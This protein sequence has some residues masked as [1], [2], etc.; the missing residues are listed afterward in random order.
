MPIHLLL[1][2]EKKIRS[3]LLCLP[4][5]IKQ[6]IAYSAD[7]ILSI[8]AVWFAFYLRTGEF[9]YLF[10]QYNGYDF[11]SANL[12][13]VIVF[14]PLFIING[15]YK[16]AFR[17]V[18]GMA[19]LNIFRA[20]LV[21]SLCY[22]LLVTLISFQGI[23]RTLGIIQPLVFFVLV[24]L[25]RLFVRL[26]LGQML[27]SLLRK[28]SLPKAIIY[29]A[30]QTGRDLSQSLTKSGDFEVI[31]FVDDDIHL[32]GSRIFGLKVS[33]PENLKSIV[34]ENG[35]SHVLLA[36][37]NIKNP[38]F[39]QIV[40]SLSGLKVS[41]KTI[42][43]ASDI[44]LQRK[45]I[46]QIRELTIDE[47][48]G[49]EAVHPFKDLL[50]KDIYYKNVLVTG[51][52]GS[53]GSELS[54]IILENKPKT[55]LLL[56]HN[57]YSLYSIEKELL[58]LGK[59]F[60]DM[61]TIVPIL[62]SVNDLDWLERVLKTYKPNTIYHA[63]AYKHVGLV[64]QNVLAG[65]RNN[66]L[67]TLDF[68]ELAS[69]LNIEK[70]VLVST[71]K[72][73]RPTSIM[74]ASKRLAELSVLNLAAGNVATTFAIVR[75]GNVLN[76]SGSVVPLFQE[77]IDRGGPVT[78]TDMRV[79]RYFMTINE[80]ASLV[81]QSGAIADSLKCKE[82]ESPIFLLD[83]GNPIKIYDLA[84][85]M[86]ELSG[87]SLGNSK[88]E[89]NNNC[90]IIFTGLKP[91]EKLTEELLIEDASFSTV[92]P[93]IKQANEATDFPGELPSLIGG[94]RSCVENHNTIEAVKLLQKSKILVKS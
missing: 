83:M 9:L 76:S 3:Y 63:A 44:V 54:R 78:V 5:K 17:F 29:G 33:K 72:A 74:G 35:I 79:T 61:P 36:M 52:G 31:G 22:S 13:T 38:R 81:I 80:A 37:P 84:V 70:F 69:E 68:A 90:E 8:F 24:A 34:S 92:H 30:G 21:Y 94:L 62:G 41:V 14:T 16:S 48:L 59:N 28:K 26:W 32:H 91:G 45:E 64:E 65:I 86:I 56:E 82:R 11:I 6:I 51:A 66:T 57:E 93:K 55:I 58:Q 19:L 18:S 85:K 42:P 53:I 87:R 27:S 23:P 15:M 89:N 88:T 39:A 10:N 71:D 46:K 73:V 12:I 40:E 60:A 1:Y 67:A 43:S 77:Q 25:S 50:T 47:V 7:L 20:F 75:F 2:L 49:R 4:R